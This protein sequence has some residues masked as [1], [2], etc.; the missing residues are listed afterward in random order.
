MEV[1]FRNRK[2]LKLCSSENNMLR[3]LGRKRADKLKMRLNELH[4][5]DN[6]SLI[7]VV[8]PSRCHEL[9]GDRQ[10]QLSVDLDHPYRLIFIPANDPVPLKPDGGLDRTKVT[11]VEILE[12]AD[13]H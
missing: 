9:A 5:M 10:G 4:A 12:I 13:T 6:L 1:F 8:P 7:P 11:A 2:L 3:D